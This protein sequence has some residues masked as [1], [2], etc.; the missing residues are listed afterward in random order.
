[1][2]DPAGEPLKTIDTR[3]VRQVEG[4][5]TAHEIDVEQHQTGHRTV[6]RLTRAAYS[7]RSSD[8][9]FTQQTLV[10]GLRTPE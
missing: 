8:D 4:I 1:M 7:F 6:L 2:W 9:M 5:W 3:D 10:R